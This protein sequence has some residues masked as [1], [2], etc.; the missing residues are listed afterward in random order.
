MLRHLQTFG[1]F[2]GMTSVW[3]IIVVERR[4]RYTMVMAERKFALRVEICE[5]RESR[6]RGRVKFPHFWV[7][8]T[9][10]FVNVSVVYTYAMKIGAWLKIQ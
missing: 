5:N 1:R 4:K 7:G 10:F 9:Q 3:E 6:R 2:V 8:F